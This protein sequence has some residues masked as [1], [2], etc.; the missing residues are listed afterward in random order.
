MK[1]DKKNISIYWSKLLFKSMFPIRK[2]KRNFSHA[3]KKIR[4]Y[5]E[6]LFMA[7]LFS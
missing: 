4:W 5:I 6:K 2:E 3:K 7:I 1:K